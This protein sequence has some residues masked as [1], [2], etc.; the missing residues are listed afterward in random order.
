MLPLTS[1]LPKP[2]CP[3]ATATGGPPFSVQTMT[4][5]L[6]SAVHDTSSVP[7]AFESAP[8]LIELVASSWTTRAKRRDGPL[9][10]KQ[11]GHGDAD[12]IP[13][14]SFIVVGVQE[15]SE[16]V[17]KVGRF[18]LLAQNGTDEFVGTAEGGQPLG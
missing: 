14:R 7:L 10:D 5:S 15:D 16:Q 2:A 17:A 13:D 11:S 9:A 1:L 18:F 6:S 8:Y 4:T 12:A 3:S